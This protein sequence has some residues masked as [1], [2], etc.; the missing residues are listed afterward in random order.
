MYLVAYRNQHL[1]EEGFEGLFFDKEE[2]EDFC[3][4]KQERWISRKYMVIEIDENRGS[5][6]ATLLDETFVNYLFDEL[7]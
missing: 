7:R 5:L 1:E 4:R 6:I 3:E 2:A